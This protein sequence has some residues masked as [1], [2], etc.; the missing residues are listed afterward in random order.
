ML[1]FWP[2]LILFA[3]G[4]WLSWSAI[5]HR[6]A[7]LAA[8]AARGGEP[9]PRLHPSLEVMADAMPFLTVVFTG[10]TCALIG[11]AFFV[12]GAQRFF[13]IFDLAGFFAAAAGYAY[14]LV[15]RASYRTLYATGPA[16]QRAP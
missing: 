1:M 7:S 13:S 16:P 11:I 4:G 15:T 5:Q 14:W 6:K 10:F 12:T 2:G 8:K 3:I 9:E